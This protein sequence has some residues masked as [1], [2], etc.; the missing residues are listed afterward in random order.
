MRN[1]INSFC[2]LFVMLGLLFVSLPVSAAET[3]DREATREELAE[4]RKKLNDAAREVAELTRELGEGFAFHMEEIAASHRKG[5]MLGVSVASI[6]RDGEIAEEGLRIAAVTP[7]SPAEE[8]G[9]RSGDILLAID[10]IELDDGVENSNQ[11]TE[12]L[13]GIEPGETVDIEFRRGDE[14][15]TV[16]VTTSEFSP[17]HFAFRFGPEGDTRTYAFTAPG[18]PD[19]PRAP[20][21]P[22]PPVFL[23]MMT[24]WADMELVPVSESLGKYFGVESGLLVVRAP[25]KG[26]T[27][28]RDG[29]VILKIGER[30]PQGVGHALRILRSYSAGEEVAIEII[31]ERKRETV[32]FTMPERN[33]GARWMRGVDGNVEII[34]QHSYTESHSASPAASPE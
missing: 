16:E 28:L 8:A 29:D 19:M 15:R 12:Y 20:R 24:G 32:R 31:R 6:E 18:M 34:E 4:A 13:G 27:E 25:E 3:A 2:L 7:G 23:D 17:R 14:T 9:L 26:D 22:R 30:E 1:L 10:D 5:A 11:L 21:A 33:W